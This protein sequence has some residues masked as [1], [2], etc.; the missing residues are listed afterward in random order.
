[1]TRH[2]NNNNYNNN[3]NNINNENGIYERTG[4]TDGKMGG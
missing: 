3:N 1:V 4:V 2:S